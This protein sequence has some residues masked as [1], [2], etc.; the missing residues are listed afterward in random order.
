MSALCYVEYPPGTLQPLTA[1]EWGRMFE[2]HPLRVV[3]HH[4]IRRVTVSTV[5]VGLDQRHHGQ[6]PP[7]IYETM[8]FG[9]P[10][11]GTTLRYTYRDE[12]IDGHAGILDAVRR[13]GRWDQIR[14][15][16]TQWR[17]G[18]R[19]ERERLLRHR[20]V[21]EPSRYRWYPRSY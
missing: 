1:Q 20:T 14:R 13:C 11:D 18:A 9:G 10:L 15:P 2:D 5:W 16:L 17:R 4:K 8:V 6:G 7:L 3:A 19:R 21:W 12:A